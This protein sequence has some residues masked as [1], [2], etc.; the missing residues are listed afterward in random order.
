MDPTTPTDSL[1]R[2]EVRLRRVTLLFGLA[3][4]AVLLLLAFA[5]FT[6]TQPD[7]LR[8]RTVSIVDEH[9]IER[10]RIGGQLPDAI[11]NGKRVPRGDQAAGVL[12]YDDAGQERGGYVT[13][14]RSRNAVLT[15]DT[16]KGMVVLLAADSSDGA[17]LRLW[18]ADFSDWLDLRASSAGAHLTVG[19]EN[20]VILQEPP[21]EDAEVAAFCGELKGEL[22]QLK[23]QPPAQE[24]LRACQQ[25]MPAAACRKCLEL[26]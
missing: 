9:G 21:L 13:F 18:G 15:L 17:A 24:V 14:N 7:E 20:N 26:R 5:W 22:R 12:I 6:L 19:R 1:A 23:V 10:V 8:L 3:I 11:V 2:L 4:V 25:R 16:R